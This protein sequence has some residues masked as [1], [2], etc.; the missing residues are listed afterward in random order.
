MKTKSEPPDIL[1]QASTIASSS[2][3]REP[4]IPSA[5]LQSLS[6]LQVQ[7]AP[8]VAKMEGVDDPHFL[9]KVSPETFRTMKIWIS[10]GLAGC[11][12]KTCTAPLSRVCVL[13][14]VIRILKTNSGDWR[15]ILVRF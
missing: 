2:N 3:N 6:T 14:Q 5:N 1:T 9:D 4:T 10:G 15:S 11:N 8:P 12:G 7:A 13:M